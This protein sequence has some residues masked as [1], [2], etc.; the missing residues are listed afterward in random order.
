MRALLAHCGLETAVEYDSY[1]VQE[2][3]DEFAM[4]GGLHR[5]LKQA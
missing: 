1:D 2:L 5:V 3:N 4:K